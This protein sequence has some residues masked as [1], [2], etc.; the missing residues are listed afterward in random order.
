MANPIR[1]KVSPE[2]PIYIPFVVNLLF[3]ILIG[4]Y[5]VYTT[6]ELPSADSLGGVPTLPVK[7]R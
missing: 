4:C 2:S 7:I 3:L 1:R 5:W 6:T